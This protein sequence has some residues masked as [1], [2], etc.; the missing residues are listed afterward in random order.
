MINFLE[1][2]YKKMKRDNSVKEM[3]MDELFFG[4]KNLIVKIFYFYINNN[5]YSREDGKKINHE[6]IFK[7][8]PHGIA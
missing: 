4:L 6:L 2:A 8:L 5:L 7:L 1:D 3:G